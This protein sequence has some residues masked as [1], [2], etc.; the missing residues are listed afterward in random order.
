MEVEFPPAVINLPWVEKYRPESLNDMISHE[1]IIKTLTRYV[2]SD[3]VPH[4]LFYGPPGTGKTS[5]ILAVVNTMYTRKQ[6]NSMVLELNASDDRGIGVVREEI[7]TFAQTKSL[8]SDKDGTTD[9]K[10]V[11][12]DEADAMTKDAQNALRRVI[13]KYTA[14]VRFCIICN[15]LSSII[16]AIQSRCTRFRFG[17]LSL[18]HIRPRLEHVIEEENLKVTDCGKEAL[19]NLSGGDM[20]RLLNVLQTSVYQCVGQPSPKHMEKILQILMN[21]SFATCCQKLQ[22]ECKEEGYAL[23]DIIARLHDLLFQLDIPSNV[24][25]CVIKAL[26]DTEQRLAVGASDRIQIGGIVAAFGR[27]MQNNNPLSNPS[28]PPSGYATPNQSQLHQQ[29]QTLGY[30]GQPG[31][32]QSQ[33]SPMTMSSQQVMMGSGSSSLS[34][35]YQSGVPQMMQQPSMPSTQQPSM[36]QQ[37]MYGAQVPRPYSGSVTNVT[38]GFGGS[39]SVSIGIGG[40]QAQGQQSYSGQPQQQQQ[41]Q[42]QTQQSGPAFASQQWQ[43]AASG[44]SQQS[45]ACSLGSNVTP[46]F[47]ASSTSGAPIHS[48][49]TASQSG[50]QASLA[51]DTKRPL[52]PPPYPSEILEQLDKSSVGTLTLIGR[53]L[54]NELT[55]RLVLCILRIFLKKKLRI[56]K[57]FGSKRLNTDKFIEIMSDMSLPTENIPTD[58]VEKRQQ[59][60]ENRTKLCTLSK[61]LKMLEWMASVSD[62][63][64]LKKE[65]P[66]TSILETRVGTDL[67]IGKIV[68]LST[69][70]I[71]HIPCA[72]VRCSLNEFNTFLKK[73]FARPFEFW[74]L[75]RESKGNLGDTVLIRRIQAQE[76]TKTTVTHAI[77]RI[78]FKY[79]NIIDP[80]TGKR[81]IKDEF[82][83]EI[84][85]RKHLVT[86][87]MTVPMQQVNVLVCFDDSLLFDERRA[88]QRQLL[89][90]R[91]KSIDKNG[92]GGFI[93]SPVCRYNT[94]KVIDN[95]SL[96]SG[97]V[98][99]GPRTAAQR[100]P[101]HMR[102]RAMAYDI[103][104]F[105]RGLR[106]FA[107]PFL[108]VTKHQKKP[109]SRFYRRRSRNLLLVSN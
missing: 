15:Y 95:S 76:S 79:G 70:G 109:P 65:M 39:S 35:N 32:A 90:E 11:I 73:Y 61:D 43:Q 47:S 34:M 105:P 78:V 81:L 56:E 30:Y 41:V 99:K 23:V 91:K 106:K 40:V 59:F 64:L 58:L 42:Q 108:A 66:R 82:A 67:L 102:R 27:N 74:A 86:E 57:K 31:P 50:S 25:I 83:D 103:R 51:K 53:E 89:D 45:Y 37:G 68:K 38:P 75:D 96:I 13:E 36:V 87:I 71:D 28:G 54:V 26:S 7:I 72:Q 20:R 3:T 18:E 97:E 22:Q 10:F 94:V 4:M 80:V 104:R 44:P 8:H 19:L 12:L 21:E 93:K 55:T 17:P 2:K 107:S 46:S 62:P 24:L 92:I 63:S 77:D 69:I 84:Q 52:N 85:L 48:T 6:R 16:P 88:T 101:R 9:L 100:L 49:V 14:N 29:Q 1:E 98:T 5:A 60:E 33:Q